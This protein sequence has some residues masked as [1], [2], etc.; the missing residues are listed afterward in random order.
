MALK[1]EKK[2]QLIKD[3]QRAE[4]DVGSS[5]V[6]IAIL[7]QRIRELT[8]HLRANPKDFA[9]RR[10][11]SMMVGRRRRLLNYY[12]RQVNVETYKKLLE[13]LKIRK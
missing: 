1:K 5:E 3:F 8:E 13:R 6:Q 10:G 9:C 12:Q 7:S 4:G 2:Q 11:L